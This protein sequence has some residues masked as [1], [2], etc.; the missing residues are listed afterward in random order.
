MGFPAYLSSGGV[1]ASGGS[2]SWR[3]HGLKMEDRR[4][5]H[6]PDVDVEHN[7]MVKDRRNFPKSHGSFTRSHATIYRLILSTVWIYTRMFTFGFPEKIEFTSQEHFFGKLCR[8]TMWW[9]WKRRLVK[10]ISNGK[11]CASFRN[12]FNAWSIAYAEEDQ[13][14]LW[15][16]TGREQVFDVASA[17]TNGAKYDLV[18]AD[19]LHFLCECMAKSE[20]IHLFG[21][22][23]CWCKRGCDLLDNIIFYSL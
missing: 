20:V 19:L 21:A 9:K 7:G 11:K 1:P 6:R 16:T 13:M 17:K 10:M 2:V 4:C 22:A 3:S 5:R 15:I 12:N 18:F 23:V 8:M 14:R